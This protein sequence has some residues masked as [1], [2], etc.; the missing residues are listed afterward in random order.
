MAEIGRLK[1]QLRDGA[2]GEDKSELRRKVVTL[3]MRLQQMNEADEVRTASLIFTE[4]IFAA[5]ICI[6]KVTYVRM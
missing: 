1:A 5:Y 2:G 3:Q 6:R 4:H